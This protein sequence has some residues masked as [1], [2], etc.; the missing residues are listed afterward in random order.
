MLVCC[1]K[2]VICSELAGH[3]FWRSLHATSTYLE[4]IFAAIVHPCT[5]K[6]T[7]SA[8]KAPNPKPFDRGTGEVCK[9]S[10]FGNSKFPSRCYETAMRIRSGEFDILEMYVLY[11]FSCT[12]GRAWPIPCLQFNFKGIAVSKCTCAKKN[13]RFSLLFLAHI[14][15]KK[16]PVSRL[17]KIMM[18]SKELAILFLFAY[19]SSLWSCSSHFSGFF[20]HSSQF[21]T[22]LDDIR[23]WLSTVLLWD[24]F[25]V[26]F[27]LAF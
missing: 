5:R 1:L 20:A 3:R 26:L 23:Y 9:R 24:H 15:F 8:A 17:Q 14:D 19:P 11:R 21:G 2:L 18:R 4:I 22:S 13:F 16:Q 7:V 6:R 12:Y 25:G 27:T 10:Q